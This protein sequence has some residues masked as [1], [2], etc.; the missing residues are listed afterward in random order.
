M[1]VSRVEAKTRFSRPL[2]AMVTLGESRE[3]GRLVWTSCWSSLGN[4]WPLDLI[5]HFG[6]WRVRRFGE[7]GEYLDVLMGS[8]VAM[9]IVM[10]VLN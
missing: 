5:E 2:S 4:T 9:A 6:V 1:A 8:I 3:A 7:S 10:I